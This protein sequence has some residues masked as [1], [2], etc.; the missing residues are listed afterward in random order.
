MG[1][2]QGA[3]GMMVTQN[4]PASQEGPLASLGCA[5]LPSQPSLGLCGSAGPVSLSPAPG[6][7]RH[8]HY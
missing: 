7:L 2:A 3:G 6:F 4:P 8:C 1:S 5:Q